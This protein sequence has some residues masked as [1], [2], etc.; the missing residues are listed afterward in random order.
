MRLIHII[1]GIFIIFNGNAQNRLYKGLE[2]SYIALNIGDVI[3]TKQFLKYGGYEL[4][5]IMRPIVSNTP[6]L[7]VFKTVGTL[8]TL[9]ILRIIKKDNPKLALGSLI[10]L[11]IGMSYVV[12]HNYQLTLTLKI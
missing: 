3:T 8:G 2:L 5:P 11:N 12:Y 6:E 1:I 7:I 10:A 4:N 9:G